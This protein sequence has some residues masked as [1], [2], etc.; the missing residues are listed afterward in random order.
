LVTVHILGNLALLTRKK[1]SAASNYDFDRK[2]AA[3]FARG[4]VSPFVL[5]TEVLA[6]K[7]WTPAVV[8]ARQSKHLAALEKLWRLQARRSPMDA[9]DPGNADSA[10]S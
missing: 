9:L 3:Y 10:T 7:E 6:H 5:T 2:K 4:G 8:E 1:N